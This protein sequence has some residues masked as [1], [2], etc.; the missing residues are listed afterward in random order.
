MFKESYSIEIVKRGSDPEF[1][2]ALKIYNNVTPVDIKTDANDI[3]YWVENDSNY[4]KMHIFKLYCNNCLIGLSMTTYLPK[5]KVLILEYIAINDI[6]QKN[7]VYLSYLNL[8][9][10]FFK[11]ST[12]SI[13]YWLTDINNKN[14]GQ[15]VDSE[16]KT[17]TILLDIEGYKKVDALFLTPELGITDVPGFEAYF[18]IKS[19]DNIS[20]LSKSSYQSIVDA[21]YFDYYLKW[22]KSRLSKEDF[23][24]YEKV[25]N[26]SYDKLKKQITRVKDPISVVDTGYKVRE[27]ITGHTPIHTNNKFWNFFKQISTQLV[28]TLITIILGAIVGL[29]TITFLLKNVEDKGAVIAATITATT[30]IPLIRQYNSYRNKTN[31]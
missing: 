15:E 28:I 3:I 16:S 9:G 21:I 5:V 14:N 26:A 10:Q 12:Y 2:E 22:Y 8:I 17:L 7:I 18:M 24:K 30:A 1:L 27:E 13:N 25:L 31:L 23:S 11:E 29:A 20:S 19:T 6:Y 4:F